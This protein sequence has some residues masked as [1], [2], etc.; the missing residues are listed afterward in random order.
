MPKL[1]YKVNLTSEERSILEKITKTGK[2]TA[3]E[4][5]RAKILLATDDNRIPKLTVIEVAAK[6][7]SN[8]TT[9]QSVRKLYHEG[10]L[11]VAIKR[12]KR[13][14]PPVAPK[15]TGDVEAHIVAMACGKPPEGFAK[16]SLK[17]LANK[18]VE[19]GY[20]DDISHV[21]VRTVLKK[22]SLS[23]I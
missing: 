12:K 1:K 10:G 23:L 7:D 15:I 18:A 11:N 22:H 14:S 17:L 19:L 5:N 20:I 8:T 6:C 4:I 13:E 9:V 2:T 16:W 3:G 21:S